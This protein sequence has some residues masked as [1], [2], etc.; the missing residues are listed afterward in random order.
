MVKTNERKPCAA[1][2]AAADPQAVQRGR[3]R[4]A[5]LSVWFSVFLLLFFRGV[6]LAAA[7]VSAPHL[8]MPSTRHGAKVVFCCSN[9]Q[10]LSSVIYL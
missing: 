8:S 5:A 1:E 3:L 7:R 6:C 4:A 9:R 2:K 10:K